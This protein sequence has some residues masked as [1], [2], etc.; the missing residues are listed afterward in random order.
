MNECGIQLE[1]KL[2]DRRF[3]ENETEIVE[4]FLTDR[5]RETAIFVRQAGMSRATFYRHH[6][7]VG[8]IIPDYREMIVVRFE[9]VRLEDL[10]VREVCLRVV[11]F[12]LRNREI[13]Q[14]FLRVSEYEIYILMFRRIWGEERILIAELVVLIEDWGKRGFLEVEVDEVLG[15]MV[16]IVKRRLALGGCKC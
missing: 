1:R 9:R 5:A 8:R 2:L 10:S 11:M 14:M 3:R 16:R 4:K 13:F 12:I 15:E 7:G 6:Q